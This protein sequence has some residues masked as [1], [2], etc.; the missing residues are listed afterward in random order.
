MSAEGNRKFDDLVRDV[1]KK[2]FCSLCGTCAATCPVNAIAIDGEP[3]L[4]GVCEECGLCYAHCPQTEPLEN[5][6]FSRVL[7]GGHYVEG[8]GHFRDAYM[9]K[10]KIDEIL[11]RAYK[12]GV[13]TSLLL[14][15]MDK[16]LID[17]AIVTR[18]TEVW[19]AYPHVALNRED[20]VSAAGTKYTSSPVVLGLAR[21]VIEMN[22]HRVA[23]VGVPC[24]I[25]AIRKM[26]Y[27]EKGYLK[28]GHAVTF[29]I[30]IFCMESLH[31][32][33]FIR[34]LEGKDINVKD[35][36]KFEI[37]KGKFIAISKDGSEALKIPVKELE[38]CMMTCRRNCGDF[39]A[40]MA[41]ISVG[42]V[43]A[44]PGWSTVVIRTKKGEM[45]FHGAVEEGYLDAVHVSD[46][47]LRLDVVM[48]LGLSKKGIQI[49]PEPEASLHP[50]ARA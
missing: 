31:Y 22:K 32:E 27:S 47:K 29:L 17:A 26:M 11:G 48:K 18:A 6:E 2:G 41:D 37:T 28:L 24:H 40:E 39:A 34:F 13:V 46:R 5:P 19:E 50:I 14:Y 1:I 36:K 45:V 30:G 15:M 35:I 3:H 38:E 12:G 21:A 10:S 16:K 20:I 9:A 44:P 7:H 43:G 4:V 8:I 33:R 49:K 42:A 23:V 25:R